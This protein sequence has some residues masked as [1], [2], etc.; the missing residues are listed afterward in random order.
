MHVPPRAF[1]HEH[2]R[3]AEGGCGGRSR[4]LFIAAPSPRRQRRVYEEPRGIMGVPAALPHDV[5]SQLTPPL[6][7]RSSS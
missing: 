2:A 7:R 6:A 1:M 4:E 3:S 5:M